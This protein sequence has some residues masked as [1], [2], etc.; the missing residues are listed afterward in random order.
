VHSE[1]HRRFPHRAFFFPRYH[2][3]CTPLATGRSSFTRKSTCLLKWTQKCA[4]LAPSSASQGLWCSSCTNSK[5]EAPPIQKFFSRQVCSFSYCTLICWLWNSSWFHLLSENN[6]WCSIPS[7]SCCLLCCWRVSIYTFFLSLSFCL[8]LRLCRSSKTRFLGTCLQTAT[9]TP[10]SH[11][12]SFTA[13]EHLLRVYPTTESPFYWC[14]APQP[15]KTSQWQTTRMCK[16]WC[17]F[18]STPF[19]VHA[20]STGC[21]ALSKTSGASFRW[22]ADRHFNAG[23]ASREAYIF[24]FDFLNT[25]SGESISDDVQC[26]PQIPYNTILMYSFKNNA[27]HIILFRHQRGPLYPSP[28]NRR[29][30]LD[31]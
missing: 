20:R 6:I 15:R 2:H 14:S 29:L 26:A 3:V 27:F 31:Y 30:C 23:M 12:V 18:R 7:L 9:L 24:S 8:S 13:P 19:R 17:R 22:R 10:L 4:F 25:K 1:V 16:R 5:F 21:A 28:C 11:R